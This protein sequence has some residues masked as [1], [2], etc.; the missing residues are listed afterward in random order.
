MVK[1]KRLNLS[2]ATDEEMQKLILEETVEEMKQAYTEMLEGCQVHPFQR[3]WYAVWFM[4]LADGSDEIIGDLCF[5]GITNDGVV[6]IGYGIQPLYEGKGYPTEAVNALVHW[7]VSQKVIAN[8][9]FVPNGEI[10]QEGPRFTWE[11]G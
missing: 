10:G 4:K 11:V 1:T 2:I 8:V 9:G 7:A 5:K 6:E 3:M